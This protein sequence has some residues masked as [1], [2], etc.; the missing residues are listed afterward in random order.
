[1]LARSAEAARR[2]TRAFKEDA[3]RKLYWALVAG[4]PVG[5]R[6]GVIDLPLGKGAGPRG[7]LMSPDAPGAKPAET[8][9]TTVAAAGKK[10]AWL[11]LRPIT[12]RTHQLR[13]HCAAAGVPILGDGKYGGRQAFPEKPALPGTLMLM[14]REIALPH[15]DDGTTLRVVAPLPPH[16]AAAFETFGF[17]PDGQ[18]A[19]EAA[20][21]LEC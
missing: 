2:L 13:A 12:G 8:R 17:D 9:F 1:L 21:Y 5:K 15:P 11:A 4:V 6:R 20:A 14:A 10:V 19:V 18:S 16:M 7:E 3:T